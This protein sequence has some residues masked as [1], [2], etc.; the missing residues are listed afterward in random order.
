ML[1]AVRIKGVLMLSLVPKE[2][3]E[4]MENGNRLMKL[5]IVA[6]YSH[7]LVLDIGKLLLQVI[8][9][10]LECDECLVEGTWPPNY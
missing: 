9:D 1:L 7:Y 10:L 5:E 8:L 4:V 3:L 2:K 6:D